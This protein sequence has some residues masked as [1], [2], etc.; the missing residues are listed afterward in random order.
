MEPSQSRLCKQIMTFECLEDINNE[1]ELDKVFNFVQNELQ[2]PTKKRFLIK[3][4]LMLKSQLNDKSIDNIYKFTKNLS[5][6]NNNNKKLE[7]SEIK[8]YCT[9]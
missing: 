9:S 1:N 8:S 5:K 6:N 7:E 3:I 4:L 2:I